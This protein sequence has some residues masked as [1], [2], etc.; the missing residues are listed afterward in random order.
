MLQHQGGDAAPVCLPPS[1]G[2]SQ[3]DLGLTQLVNDALKELDKQTMMMTGAVEPTGRPMQGFK[4]TPAEYLL[5]LAN[6]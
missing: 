1:Q 3:L 2:W 5:K 6:V 4:G